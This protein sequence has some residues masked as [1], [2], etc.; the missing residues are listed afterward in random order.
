MGQIVSV[1]PLGGHTLLGIDQ[2]HHFMTADASPENWVPVA[3]AGLP[4]APVTVIGIALCG[5]GTGTSPRFAVTGRS[6]RR[7]SPATRS[8]P[9]RSPLPR[10]PR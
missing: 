5:A 9:P 3:T 8:R 7:R 6:T 10:T 2:N 4:A 1:T